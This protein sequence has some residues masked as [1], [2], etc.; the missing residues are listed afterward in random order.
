VVISLDA[1]GHTGL[2]MIGTPAY[3]AM[4]STAALAAV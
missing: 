3:W 2:I 4:L 1:P